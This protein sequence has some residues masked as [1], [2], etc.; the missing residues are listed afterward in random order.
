MALIVVFLM[1]LFILFF[2]VENP[3]VDQ[4]SD[5]LFKVVRKVGNG[6]IIFLVNVYDLWLSLRTT[7]TIIQKYR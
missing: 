1:V 2:Y 3:L 4:S 6:I 7:F 5:E